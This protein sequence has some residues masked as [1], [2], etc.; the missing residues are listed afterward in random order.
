[1]LTVFRAL[2]P[3]VAGLTVGGPS[4]QGQQNVELTASRFYSAEVGTVVEAL[5]RV[6]F[7]ILEP[8]RG[9]PD[10]FG[11]YQVGVVVR[12]ST[13]LALTEDQWSQRVPARVMRVPGASAVEH[14][15]FAAA[16]GRYTIEVSVRDS[17]SGLVKRSD[18][19]VRAFDGGPTVSDLLLSPAIRQRD[20]TS[21]TGSGEISRGGFLITAQTVPVLTPSQAQLFYYL[22][23]YPGHEST[24]ELTARVVDQDGHELIST[25]PE[26]VTI[27]AAGVAASGL[28]LAGLPPGEYQLELVVGMDGSTVRRAAPFRMAGFE[29]EAAIARAVEDRAAD[30]FA[31]LTEDQLDTL[32]QPLV[33]IME[34]D[35]RGIYDD[36][37]VE[38][39][40]NYLRQFW[41]RRDPTP[42]TPDN[43]EQERFYAMIAYANREFR[44]SGAG[45]VPGWRTDRGR[46]FIRYGP[47]DEVLRRPASGPTPPYEAWKYTS[48]R[49]RKFVF[50]DRTRLGNYTLLYT[51]ERREPS[52]PDWEDILGP[53]AVED[54]NRF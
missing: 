13:G 48:G 4:V 53:E 36:L 12:D 16:E 31:N 34:R 46:I 18:I 27:S 38:G 23:L 52:L 49:L 50:L 28:N 54:I 26:A 8:L 21:V 10:A 45:D 30:V 42:A 40:R 20:S 15:R 5:C 11:V 9:G 29:T 24:V 14:F 35:E 33:H 43:P 22:E 39:K 47:P 41:Q 7:G 6:P 37:S 2:V 44:E 32:Y 1:M 19:E 25:A 17:A 3:L 51:N